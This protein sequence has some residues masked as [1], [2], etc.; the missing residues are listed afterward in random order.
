MEFA[1]WDQLAQRGYNA[2]TQ[3]TTEKATNNAQNVKD[4]RYHQQKTHVFLNPY[5]SHFQ[6]KKKN[7]LC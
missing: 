7:V 4:G 6:K 2:M 5:W 1:H 3:G